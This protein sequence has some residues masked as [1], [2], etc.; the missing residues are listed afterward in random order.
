MLLRLPAF[1]WLSLWLRR[2][3][4]FLTCLHTFAPVVKSDLRLLFPLPHILGQEMW[5]IPN[6]PKRTGNWRTGDPPQPTFEQAGQDSTR[7]WDEPVSLG[8]WKPTNEEDRQTSPLG[9]DHLLH[10]SFSPS[11]TSPPPP[12]ISNRWRCYIFRF[13]RASTDCGTV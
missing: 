10:G 7:C 9:K 1:L 3:T 13:E 2:H 8:A 4:C 6:S 11:E 5:L 12:P